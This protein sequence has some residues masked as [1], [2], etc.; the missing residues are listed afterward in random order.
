MGAVLAIPLLRW[1]RRSE[2]VPAGDLAVA[3]NRLAGTALA[4]GKSM[5]GID[6]A[7]R[8]WPAAGVSLLILII[9]LSAAIFAH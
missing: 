2:P 3:I 6:G 1:M 4:W 8:Q 7:L 5:E 9:A